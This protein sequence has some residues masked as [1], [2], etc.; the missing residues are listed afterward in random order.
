[1]PRKNKDLTK[2]YMEDVPESEYLVSG[3]KAVYNYPKRAI[4]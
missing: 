2:M 4:R 1:M 3:Y